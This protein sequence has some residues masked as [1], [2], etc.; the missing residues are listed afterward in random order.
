M[1]KAGVSLSE[2]QGH[3]PHPLQSRVPKR[4]RCPGQGELPQFPPSPEIPLQSAL[5]ASP[6]ATGKASVKREPCLLSTPHSACASLSSK[7][8]PRLPVLAGLGHWSSLS[9]DLEMP[10]ACQ[11]WKLAFEMAPARPAEE[12]SGS[13]P[14]TYFHVLRNSSQEPDLRGLKCVPCSTGIASSP[15]ALGLSDPTSHPPPT[16]PADQAFHEVTGTGF[17]LCVKNEARS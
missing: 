7:V 4:W 5:H 12:I 10:A 6:A 11:A 9:L 8:C 1:G 2:K 17:I 3:L 14:E 13:S 15:H 16:G